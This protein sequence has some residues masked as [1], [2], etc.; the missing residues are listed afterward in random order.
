MVRHAVSIIGVLLTTLGFLAPVRAGDQEQDAVEGQSVARQLVLVKEGVSQAPIVVF[1]SAPPKT[2]Q[3]AE[4]LAEYIE[5]ISGARP[6]LIEGQPDSVPEHSIWVGYQPVLDRLFPGLDFNFQHQEEVLIAANEDHLV[7]AGRDRWDEDHLVVQ[8]R[9]SR[10]EGWQREYGT[11]NAVYTFLQDYLD[12][13]W[14]M[15]GEIGEDIIKKETIALEPF[16]YRHHPPFVERAEILR[17]SRAGD[18][19]RHAQDWA[20]LQRIQLD[21]MSAPGGHSA[22]HW[23]DKYHEEHPDYFALQPDGTRSGYPSP[24]YAKRCLSN[25]AVWQRWIEEVEQTFE[26]D[27]TRTIFGGNENDSHSSGLCVCEDCR[28]WD[29]SPED[30]KERHRYTWDGV[31]R[32]YV[33]MSDRY[34]RFAN[35][36]GRKLKE[37]FPDRPDLRVLMSTYGPASPAPVEA[38]PDDNVIVSVVG[39]FPLTTPDARREQKSHWKQW[40]AKAS[41][42]RY[43]PN[44]WYWGG[45]IW[46]WPEVAMTRTIEDFRFL[47]ENGGTGM[48]VD[49]AWEHWATQGPMYYL[50]AHL[51]W[52]P[53]QDGQALLDDYYRRGFG[54]AADEIETYW[55]MMERAN[56]DFMASPNLRTRS[57]SRFTTIAIAKQVYNPEFL[58]RADRVLQRAAEELAD[59]PEVYRQRVAFVRAGFDF[60]RLMIECIPLMERVRESEGRDAEAVRQAS[61]NWDRIEE[62]A[63]ET[64]PYGFWFRVISSRMQ[65]GYMG[66]VADYLGPPSDT[67]RESA[68]LE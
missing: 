58:A 63:E 62:I 22:T 46:G 37:R 60:T 8:G 51:A 54:E 33:P 67:F 18:S 57:A 13:R 7:I 20:R 56:R 34:V 64:D 16:E 42:M 38:T 3:A 61:A 10:I 44:L 50:M 2:R 43:R 48:F 36:L 25:P 12:V 41:R 66:G 65:D 47:A 40:A 19:R 68:G 29:P 28:A 17:F 39:H 21:S 14:I 30:V 9:N 27:P 26:E 35:R 49:G 5:K 11:V 31:T 45:G 6:D 24:H 23:W 55:S 52:N 15:P 32:E 53:Y 59:Q 1:K 4:E